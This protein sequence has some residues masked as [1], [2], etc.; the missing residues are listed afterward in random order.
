MDTQPGSDTSKV[1]DPS[2]LTYENVQTRWF[3]LSSYWIV[4]ILALPFWWRTTSIE[5]LSLPSHRIRA[6]VEERPRLAVTLALDRSSFGTQV[7]SVASEVNGL[8]EA[9]ASSSR[10]RG[11]DAKVVVGADEKSSYT[12]SAGKST[13]VGNRSLVLSSEDVK[14]PTR[15]AELLSDLVAPYMATADNLPERVIQYAPRYRLAFSLLNENAASKSGATGWDVQ[16]A[17]SKHF[18]PVLSELGLLHNFT[19][20][21]QVQYHSPLA[22]Q[23][24]IIDNGLGLTHDQLTVFVNSAE[25]TLASSVSNDPVLHFVLFVPSQKDMPMY[26]LD[27]AGRPANSNGFLLPQWGGV[28]VLNTP[29]DQQELVHLKE[30]DLLPVFS[31]FVGQF[32]TLMGV[33][34]LPPDVRSLETSALSSWQLDALLRRRALENIHGSQDTLHSIIKLV[35]EIENMPVGDVVRDEVQGSLDLLEEAYRAS[36]ISPE[37]T[38]KWSSQ[39]LAFASRAFFDPGMLALLYFPAEHKY[40]V[41]TPLFASISVPLIVALVREFKAWKLTRQAA[42]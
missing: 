6:Q 27:T 35:E 21:S 37:L 15:I 13:V 33:A 7:D 38:L 23:P 10:W 2:R 12:V 18:N 29:P 42:Q 19:I 30:K 26:I 8:L 22:F 28:Y 40:A 36:S 14:R 9:S 41:Y 3:V 4:I 20:E 17:I 31:T 5:R 16:R 1:K 25:W 24:E 11:I 39:A 32:L 34:N